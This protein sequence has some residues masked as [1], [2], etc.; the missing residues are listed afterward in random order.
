MFLILHAHLDCALNLLPGNDGKTARLKLEITCLGWH[1]EI[2]RASRYNKF[3]PDSDSTSVWSS[4]PF[5]NTT[6]QKLCSSGARSRSS[7]SRTA[8][9]LHF[10]CMDP[11]DIDFIKWCLAKRWKI[12]NKKW[13]SLSKLASWNFIAM[14]KWSPF[15]HW[16]WSHSGTFKRPLAFFSHSLLNLALMAFLVLISLVCRYGVV[17]GCQSH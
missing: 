4:Y 16:L 12:D 3:G 9:W 1:R 10:S 7:S 14:A 15:F 17:I 13:D 8:W 5:W 6:P 11:M 2:G